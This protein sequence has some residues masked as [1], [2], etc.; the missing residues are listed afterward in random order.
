M[1]VSDFRANG[2]L[3]DCGTSKTS[4]SLISSPGLYPCSISS[5]ILAFCCIRE[6]SSAAFAR[7]SVLF[8]V[9]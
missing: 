8:L 5:R 2:R 1:L 3:A 6:T 7:Q 4:P 9:S